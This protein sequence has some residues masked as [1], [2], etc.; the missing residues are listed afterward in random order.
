MQRLYRARRW[1]REMKKEEAVLLSAAW[2]ELFLSFF[3]LFS[4]PCPSKAE[5]HQS[6]TLCVAN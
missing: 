3:P 4:T 1:Q 2:K 5:K 6:G